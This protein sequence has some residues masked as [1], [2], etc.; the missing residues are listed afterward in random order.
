M[1]SNGER[2]PYSVVRK[3]K[4]CDKHQYKYAEW[5]DGEFVSE[6]DKEEMTFQHF[7]ADTSHLY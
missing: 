1:K 7:V 6:K 3:C 5:I 2:Y 4:R